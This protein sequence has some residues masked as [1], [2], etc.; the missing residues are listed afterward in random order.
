MT[1]KRTRLT[2]TAAIISAMMFALV[3]AS[4]ANAIHAVGVVIG[5]ATLSNGIPSNSGTFGFSGVA[6]GVINGNTAVGAPAS[7]SG[8]YSNPDTVFGDASGTI[9]IAGVGASA[10]SWDRVGLVAT[11]EAYGATFAAVF[12]PLGANAP[13]GP[14]GPTQAAVI[15]VGG[16]DS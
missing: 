5:T 14:T 10:L 11:V 3:P 4:P 8:S 16:V 13:G 15:A 12:V 6:S 9:T 2:L 1:L 7:A